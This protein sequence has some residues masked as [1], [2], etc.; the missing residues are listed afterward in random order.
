MRVVVTMLCLL[1]P[2]PLFAQP[3]ADPAPLVTTTTNYALRVAKEGLGAAYRKNYDAAAR[4]LAAHEYAKGLAGLQRIVAACEAYE[5]PGLRLVAVHD[6]DEYDRFVARSTDGTP[7]EWLDMVCPWSLKLLAF[8]LVDVDGDRDEA[9]RRLEQAARL[10][11]GWAAPHV[12][13]GYILASGGH[14]AEALAA[15][16]EGV[17]LAE[18]SGKNIPELA[19]AWRGVGRVQ[20]ELHDWE[21][22]RAA[23]RRSLEVEPGNALAQNELEWIET[24]DPSGNAPKAAP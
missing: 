7:V 17:A 23:Y 11:P 15:Y 20:G 1:I 10:A 5:R 2:T 24:Q 8:T 6:A 3:T 14:F 16:R 19:M 18:A 9:V 21:S 13:R 4:Q 22:A 12:E